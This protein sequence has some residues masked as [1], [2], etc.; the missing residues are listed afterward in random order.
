MC[1]KVCSIQYVGS[2]STKFRLRFNNHKSRLR[3]HVKHSDSN[4]ERDD[5][6]HKYFNSP[7]H[8]GLVDVSIKLI[9]KVVEETKLQD[10]EG[11]WAYR[12]K[13]LHPHGLDECTFS[14]AKTEGQ[15]SGDV[16]SQFFHACECFTS[17]RSKKNLIFCMHLTSAH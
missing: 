3:D 16:N 10:K 4:K 5:L 2:T 11:Q 8:N 7:G 12:L 14:L 13:S 9:D 1:C 17:A 15:E 6:F